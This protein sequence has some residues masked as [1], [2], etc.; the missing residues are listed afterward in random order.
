MADVKVTLKR[1]TDTQGNTDIIKPTTDW[2]QVEDKPTTFTPT[3]HTHDVS[4]ITGAAI[5]PRFE[6]NLVNDGNLWWKI[7]SVNLGSGGLSLR[8]ALNNHVESFGTQSMDLHI[9][10]READNATLI[11]VDGTFEVA[12]PGVGVR[13]LRINAGSPYAQYDVYIKTVSY[14]QAKIDVIPYG[15]T[16]LWIGT[17]PASV[18]P[19]GSYGVEFDNTTVGEGAYYV[20]ASIIRNLWHQGNFT[21]SSYVAKAGDTMTGDLTIAKENPVLIF[22]DTSTPDN[23]NLAAWISFKDQNNTEKGWMG[24]GYTTDTNMTFSN[25][26]GNINLTPSGNVGIGTT[27]PTHALD[28]VGEMRVSVAPGTANAYGRVNGGDQYHSIVM[29][30]NISGTTSQ[31]VNPSDSMTFAEYG[32]T[33]RFKQLSDSVNTDLMT[34]TT[35]GLGIGTDSPGQKL[36]VNGSSR[37]RDTAFFGAADDQGVLSWNGNGFVVRGQSGKG[38]AF[39]ANANNEHMYITTGGNVGIG[40]LSPPY[41]FSVAGVSSSDGQI[42][43]QSAT[44][45]YMNNDPRWDGDLGRMHI[46][47]TKADGSQYGQAGLALWDGDSYNYIDSIGNEILINNNAVITAGNISSQSVAVTKWVTSNREQPANA[48]QY[49]EASGLGSSEAPTG[50][51]YNT[52]RMSHGL[53]LSYYSNTL[54]VKMTGSGEGDIYT[55]TIANGSPLGWKKHWNDGNDGSGSGLDADLLDGVEGSNYFRVDGTYPNADMNTPVE[56][57]WHIVSNATGVPIG[58]YGHRWDYDHLNNG[59]W[60]AQ[61]YSATSGEDSLW[62]RQRRNYSWQSWQRLWSST[63]DGAGSGLDADLLDGAHASAFVQTLSFSDFT[64]GT[65]VRTNI[66]YSQW[67]GD[68]FQFEIEG[69]S[70]GGLFPWMVRGQGY[71]Y[72]DT[73]INQGVFDYS[74][75]FP[76]SSLRAFNLSG[77]LCLWW[78]SISYWNSFSVR[79]YQSSYAGLVINRV[80]SIENTA[81]PSGRTKEVGFSTRS[82]IHSGNI[83]S[84]SVN[85]AAFSGWAGTVYLGGNSGKAIIE[86]AW[87]GAAGYPGYQFTG[88][89][90]RFGFSST[91][92]YVDVYTDGNFYAGIDL[93]GQNNRV[94]H[95]GNLSFSLDGTTLTIT[96]S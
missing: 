75:N 42:L 17:S 13:V 55:Q 47:A 35:T 46:W 71:I 92:G 18:Q 25:T 77:V 94:W 74:A 22:K 11:S 90:S 2:D 70:Y 33:F 48:L 31:T 88:G 37:F 43:F 93:N 68:S 16:V 50:D 34:L 87:A 38:L 86:S 29:R 85:Y 57:Y 82:A 95:G 27:S 72:N 78:P 8:G 54:A 65:L 41:K 84:Q 76:T 66:D 10:G 60:V 23:N 62:F 89:N 44:S 40:T 52:I 56:G 7:A 63:N 14:T 19:S 5:N 91:S 51:W 28:V 53:P 21:P 39:G 61:M 59:Q 9:F 80:T 24:Y 79:V 58:Q 67:A 49:W 83:G 73:I 81:I 32:G 45:R 30:G 96:T 15:S 12:H 6:V 3:A 1:V 69:K 36:D 20:G 64:L 4:E 26:I